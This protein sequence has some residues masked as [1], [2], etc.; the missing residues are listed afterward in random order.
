M[1][2]GVMGCNIDLPPS[3]PKDFK[4]N[5]GNMIHAN[6]PLG[7]FQ[8][9]HHSTKTPRF[10]NFVNESCSHLI[11]TLANSVRLGEEEHVRYHSLMKFLSQINKPVVIFGLGA[12]GNSEE[13]LEAGLPDATIK[14]LQ[15][16]DEKAAVIGVRGE[17][18][19]RVI[20]EYAGVKKAFVTGCPSL[21]SPQDLVRRLRAKVTV[22]GARP[23][24]AGTHF[25][26]PLE[27]EMM[28]K[29]IRGSNYFIEPVNK[30]IHNFHEELHQGPVPQNNFPYFIRTVQ[31]TFDIEDHV[32]ESYFKNNYRLFR[33]LPTCLRFLE[34]YVSFTYGT[35]FHVNMASYLSGRPAMW[36]THDTRTQEL[37]DYFKLPH[38]NLQ[39]ASQRLPDEIGAAIDLEPFYDNYGTVTRRFNEFL[40][41][42]G[43]PKLQ[44][45]T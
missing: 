44:F 33:D 4:D 18:T 24:Y 15:F 29:A 31:K 10:A 3:F 41:I 32:V 23:A 43:L 36:I 39:D 22:T 13:D 14:Y 16:L 19:K 28:G 25:F 21:F 40:S 37:I 35:R 2:I 30:L 34:K 7:M 42:A 1:A 6:A 20:E 38:M 17:F 8:G 26:K 9:C 5:A 27:R 12:Q 11:L 45:K